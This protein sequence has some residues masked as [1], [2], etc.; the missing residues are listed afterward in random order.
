MGGLKSG[1]AAAL[2]IA[3]TALVGSGVAGAATGDLTYRDCITGDTASGPIGTLACAT[4]V[5]AS[6]G[7]DDS[8]FGFLSSV[9]LSADG[10]SLYGAS[11]DDD[12]VLRLRRDT[13]T[14]ALKFK[15]C[16]TG[17]RESGPDGS[18]ACAE[19]PGA[20]N[21]GDASGLDSLNQVVSS[22]DGKS[23]Y[24]TSFD[25][26]SVVRLKRDTKTGALTYRGCITGDEESGADGS[27]ACTAI[28]AA[29]PGGEDSGLDALR[30]L[31]VSPDGRSLYTTSEDDHSVARFKRDRRTG[32]LT[33]K[34]CITG[35]PAS[36]PT[37]SGAC[38]EIPSVGDFGSG[39]SSLYSVV[40]SGDG[41]SV[42]TAARNDSAVA[43]FARNTRTG[44]LTYKGCITGNSSFSVGGTEACAKIPS[45]TGTG[46]G[47]G[48]D[49]PNA[50][51]LS[52]DGA[53]LY[54]AD[55]GGDSVAR[56]TRNT[57]TGSLTYVDCVAGDDG[58]G[59]GGTM[60]CTTIA[61]ASPG[62]GESGL[63]EPADLTVSADGRSLY[64]AA[65][66][67]QAVATFK[68]NVKTGKLI[69]RTCITGE[70]Q[71]GPSGTGA[72]TAIP[73]AAAFGN[74]SGLGS[75]VSLATSDDGKSLYAAS[76]LDDAVARFKRDR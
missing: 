2:T 69:Y 67:D 72:C 29:S 75:P 53:S 50:L 52:A 65:R 24:A 59:S 70:T 6:P 16:I 11:G 25:D 14:G 23:L 19:V 63:D 1:I 33:Y 13:K 10:K 66:I 9:A 73:S 32:A 20:T 61:A 4:A 8:G 28:P 30:S 35:E 55:D 43:R 58:L 76:S 64:V 57:R 3:G 46:G 39:L 22:A 36:G 71:S 54:A 49:S 48:L 31:A 68:R 74:H 17:K 40:V 56:F 42:Y 34:G 38:S 26:D 37:G 5:T 60:A 15:G 51:A 45:A 27:D 12:A 21:G 47:S 44:S 41:R 62:G 7:A 18:D